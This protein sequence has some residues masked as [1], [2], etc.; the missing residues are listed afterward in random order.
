MKSYLVAFILLAFS[1]NAFAE[2][3]TKSLEAIQ[4]K[5]LNQSLN[6]RAIFE[7]HKIRMDVGIYPDIWLEEFNVINNLVVVINSIELFNRINEKDNL[8]KIRLGQI[9][10][11]MKGS[12]DI[13]S[14]N[15]ND[16]KNNI[17]NAKV[18]IEVASQ[19]DNAKAACDAMGALGNSK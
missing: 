17:K 6:L 4:T 18:R 9:I 5:M 15:L 8:S 13:S 3:D 16:Y 2:Y 1:L 11:T 12:C 10:S 7:K 14:L 19:A